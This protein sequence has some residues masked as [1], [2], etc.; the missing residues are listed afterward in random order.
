[1]GLETACERRAG[2]LSFIIYNEGTRGHLQR[3]FPYTGKW[4]TRKSSSYIID[5]TAAFPSK[6]Y[7]FLIVNYE[8]KKGE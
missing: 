3:S 2:S 4:K 1:M 8:L 7:E 6:N 5:K